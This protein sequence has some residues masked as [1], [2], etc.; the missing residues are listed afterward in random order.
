MLITNSQ[1]K[2][3]KNSHLKAIKKTDEKI[4]FLSFITNQTFFG[5]QLF[6]SSFFEKNLQI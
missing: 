1:N 3:Q 5:P 4:A 6:C 2:L